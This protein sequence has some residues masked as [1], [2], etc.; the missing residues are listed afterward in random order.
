LQLVRFV[1]GDM[2]ALDENDNELLAGAAPA[3]LPLFMQQF[4]GQQQQ[5]QQ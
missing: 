2:Q 3:P 4:L 1:K 5:Q